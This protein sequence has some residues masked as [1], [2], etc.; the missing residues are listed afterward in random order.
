VPRAFLTR[1]TP[2]NAHEKPNLAQLNWPHHMLQPH[3]AQACN[4]LPGDELSVH[5]SSLLLITN[6]T[7]ISS[8]SH[9]HN[10]TLHSKAKQLSLKQQWSLSGPTS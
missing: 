5:S 4:K 7:F 9:N 8:L 10:Q 2:S 1:H 6:D 3:L